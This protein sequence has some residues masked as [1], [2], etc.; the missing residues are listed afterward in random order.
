M[1][2][3]EQME[4]LGQTN[5]F[6]FL[7]IGYKSKRNNEFIEGDPVKIQFYQDEYNFI[8]ECHPHLLEAGEVIGKHLDFYLV[9]IGDMVVEVPG[10]KLSLV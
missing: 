3:F 10:E 7:P 5:I 9:R 1:T 6:E 4:Q 8:I 2:H